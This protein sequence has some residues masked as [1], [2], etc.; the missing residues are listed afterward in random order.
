MANYPSPLSVAIKGAIAGLAGTAAITVAMQKGPQLLEERLGVSMTPESPLPE[1]V[2]EDPTAELAGRVA[3]GVLE[4]P[5]REESK[6]TA[7]QAIHWGYGAMWGTVYGILHTS[8]RIP[9]LL[10][11]TLFGALVGTVASTVV[12][13]MGLAPSPTEQPKRISAM[14]LGYH[15]VFGWVTALT[16]WL[17]TLRD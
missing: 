13:A 4:K 9:A 15:L 6:Q 17:L 14:Q 3:E 10:S 16:F 8:L 1:D 12:P 7:G 5:L 2:P 11:G